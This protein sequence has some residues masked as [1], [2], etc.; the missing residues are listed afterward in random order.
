MAVYQD[1][2]CLLLMFDLS[3]AASFEHL[4]ATLSKFLSVQ[5]QSQRQ[6]Q[7]PRKAQSD[8][9]GAQAKP[10][11]T[12]FCAIPDSKAHIHIRNSAQGT[13]SYLNK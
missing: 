4:D 3:S 6:R 10:Y 12:V 11:R 9:N 8:H 1:I 5:S 2:Q 13:I 7:R